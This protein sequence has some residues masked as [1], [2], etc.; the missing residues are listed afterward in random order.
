MTAEWHH[1]L[2]LSASSPRSTWLDLAGSPW[3]GYKAWGRPEHRSD[4]RLQRRPLQEKRPRCVDSLFA[5]VVFGGQSRGVKTGGVVGQHPVL[6][7]VVLE[8]RSQ[9]LPTGSLRFHR[10]PSLTVM[11]KWKEV[12]DRSSGHQ[13]RCRCRPLLFL[14]RSKHWFCA[15]RLQ[16][17]HKYSMKKMFYLLPEIRWNPKSVSDDGITNNESPDW[18]GDPEATHSSRSV[19]LAL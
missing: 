9:H 11:W 13:R 10:F 4:A 19:V 1:T 12:P 18:T 16:I 17:K 5:G 15:A 14:N 8:T 6:A 7:A 3:W 2:T